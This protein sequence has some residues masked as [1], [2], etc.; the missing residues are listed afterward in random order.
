MTTA[1][2]NITGLALN[3]IGVLLLFRYGMPFRLPTG[4]A[5]FAGLLVVSDTATD[6]TTVIFVI[7]G[8][9]CD[10]L[11]NTTT[12]STTKDTATHI[13]V[14]QDAGNSFIVTIQ[15]KSGVS[16]TLRVM[17]LRIRDTA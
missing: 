5:N 6:G 16:R 9:F 11:G 7:G 15:N 12:Y 2:L 10:M 8:S 14:Y 4:G 3:L 17:A 1:A 13:N